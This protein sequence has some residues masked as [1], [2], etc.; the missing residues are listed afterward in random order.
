M[1]GADFVEKLM[2]QF[3]CDT[4]TQLAEVLGQKQPNI[5]NW[6][7]REKITATVAAKAMRRLAHRVEVEAEEVRDQLHARQVA[8]SISALVEYAPIAVWQKPGNQRVQI[9][10]ADGYGHLAI[11]DTL[12]HKCGIYIFYSSMCSPIYVGK[13]KETELWTECN[14]AFNRDL[15]GDLSRV[16]HSV[17]TRNAPKQLKLARNTA[18]VY[19]VASY[20]S[21]YEVD[22]LLVDKVEALMIRS[23]INQ[24]ANVKIENLG[25]IE[26]G[27]I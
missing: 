11:R 17:E 7:N 18:K 12:E 21:A 16:N 4:E 9:R 10:A 3:E 5:N 15:K 8:H 26:Q 22:K 25:E 20:V 13:A 2:Q 1:N 14:S 23:F 27:E 24:L 6:K 19:E